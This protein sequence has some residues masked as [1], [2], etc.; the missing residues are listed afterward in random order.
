MDCSIEHHK[1][2]RQQRFAELEVKALLAG[3]NKRDYADL[4]P[5]YEVF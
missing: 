4:L 1:A 3:A 5:D 2:R